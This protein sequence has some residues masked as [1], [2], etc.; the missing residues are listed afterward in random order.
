[1]INWM[2]LNNRRRVHQREIIYGRYRGWKIEQFMEQFPFY[3][4]IALKYKIKFRIFADNENNKTRKVEISIK[5]DY[6]SSFCFISQTVNHFKM[7]NVCINWCINWKVYFFIAYDL[8]KI[9]FLID[10]RFIKCV[11]SCSLSFDLFN[12]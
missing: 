4:E 6:D 12:C 11:Y 8:F 9:L 3:V 10:N 5:A 7:H 1:M 2:A